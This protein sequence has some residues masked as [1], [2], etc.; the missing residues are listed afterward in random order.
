MASIFTRLNLWKTGRDRETGHAAVHGVTKSWTQL[1]NFTFTF[2]FHALEKAMATHSSIL[3]WRIPGTGEP[4]GLP[5]LGSHRIGHN[6]SDLAAAEQTKSYFSN[7]GWLTLV[8]SQAFLL[9]N[10]FRVGV[11]QSTANSTFLYNLRS[12][13]F[14]IH[15]MLHSSPHYVF[16]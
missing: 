12:F 13:S 9:T 14:K 6:W 5:S 10:S 1:S 3:A 4:G 16:V 15:I 8:D 2:H 11:Q 7:R